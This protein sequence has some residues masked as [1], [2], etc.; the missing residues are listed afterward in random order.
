MFRC[1][2]PC[3]AQLYPCP[4]IYNIALGSDSFNNYWYSSTEYINFVASPFDSFCTR[5]IILSTVNC[6]YGYIT[7]KANLKLRNAL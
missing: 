4:K 7:M 5:N 2:F 1:L 6:L 3:N